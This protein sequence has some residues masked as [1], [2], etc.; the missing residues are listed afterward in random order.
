[1]HNFYTWFTTGIH[2]IADLNGYDHILFLM[3]LCCSYSISQW[4]NILINITA[5]TLGHS[6]T[7]ALSVLNIIK[8][9]STLIEFLIPITIL[10]TCLFNIKNWNTAIIKQ[11][12]TTYWIAAFFGLIH[13]LGFATLLKQMLGKEQSIIMPL[14]SFNL[15]LEAG[16]LII[17]FVIILLSVLLIFLLKIKQN[18]WSFFISSAVFGI[19]AIMTVERFTILLTKMN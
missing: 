1:M 17:I 7:L 11:Q 12:K 4:K 19:A 6:F 13:G 16:Q 14:F 5:F 10:I 2:H 15:G 3:V 9:E 8:I 18:N